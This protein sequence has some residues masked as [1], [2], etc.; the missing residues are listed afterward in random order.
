MVKVHWKC[1]AAGRGESI[2]GAIARGLRSAEC[3]TANIDQTNPGMT[4]IRTR[5]RVHWPALTAAAP[6]TGC[7]TKVALHDSLNVKGKLVSI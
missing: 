3:A 4:Q 6:G 1:R 7:P 5:Q 2:V